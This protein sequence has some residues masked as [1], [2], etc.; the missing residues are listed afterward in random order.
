MARDEFGNEQSIG[1][2]LSR[3]TQEISDL[4]NTHM[5]L[6]R[7]EIMSD[8]RHIGR[9]AGMLGGA[10]V[11]GY[12]AAFLASVAAAIGLGE[13]VALWAGFLIVAAVWAAAAVV[14]ALVGRRQ[15]QRTNGIGRSTMEEIERDR[16]WMRRRSS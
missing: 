3:L 14:L 6:A 10:G 15:L 9:G 8:L 12:V 11:A 2:L 1:E 13:V 5:Q 4:V 16:E 7:M